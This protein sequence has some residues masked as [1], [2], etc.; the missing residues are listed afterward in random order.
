MGRSALRKRGACKGKLLKLHRLIDRYS[1]RVKEVRR[2]SSVRVVSY[3]F[4]VILYRS[5]L[6]PASLVGL[7]PFRILKTW[8]IVLSVLL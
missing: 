2:V 4:R 3:A 1:Q 8:V 6:T 5:S 7:I